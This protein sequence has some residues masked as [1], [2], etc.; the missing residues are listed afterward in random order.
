W[1]RL[2]RLRAMLGADLNE[3]D[4]L[5]RTNFYPG[6]GLF[7][8]Y[9][10]MRDSRCQ[11]SKQDRAAGDPCSKASHGGARSHE[12]YKKYLGKISRRSYFLAGNSTSHASPIARPYRIL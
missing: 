10:S 7:M 5:G 12:R 2:R 1:L 11:G 6:L 9:E 3:F 8:R 4:S